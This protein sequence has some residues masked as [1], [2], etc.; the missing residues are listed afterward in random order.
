MSAHH[1]FA[2]C[3]A[4]IQAR[5]AAL[6][7]DAE[8][9]RL[10]GART[11]SGFVEEARVGPLQ[12]WVKGFSRLS[13]GHELDRGL[14][15]LA[16][17]LAEEVSG[18]VPSR[19][20]TAVRWIAWL[21][22]LPVFEHLSR[23]AT[24]P[25]WMALDY[26]LGTLLNQEGA[27]QAHAL[28]RQGLSPLVSPGEPTQVVPHWAEAWRQRWPATDPETRRHLDDFSAVIDSHLAAFRRST[29]DTAWGLRRALRER[30]RLSF[31]QRLLEPVTVFI[32]LALVLLDL[33]RLRAELLRRCL[34]PQNLAGEATV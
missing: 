15:N 21:P 33:E 7:T 32:Y 12:P 1:G 22:F 3:Q 34:F 20:Q 4:R 24:P 25:D 27:L 19:W 17:D 29:P 18:W 26:R 30:L 8:W 16:A 28:E 10:A 31:H 6:P 23:G 5:Y 11:F 13:R 14:R 9:Q 2:Q